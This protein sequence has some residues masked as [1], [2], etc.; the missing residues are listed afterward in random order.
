[1]DFPLSH[2]IRDM[3]C[4]DTN[5][6]QCGLYRLYHHL[7]QDFVYPDTSMLFRFI[8][9][10]DVD[11]FF[12]AEPHDI[13]SLKQAVAIIATI[14]GIPQLY[15]G[16]EVLLYGDRSK[17]DGFIRRDFP[18]GWTG[19]PRNCFKREGRTELQNEAF[20]FCK[21][22]FT[23]RKHSKAL[24]HGSMKMFRPQHGV[25]QRPL[26]GPAFAIAHTAK[27]SVQ[28]LHTHALSY[29]CVRR[30]RALPSPRHYARA[31]RLTL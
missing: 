16:T 7:S 3:V 22:I 21:T 12:T 14:P 17:C 4:V 1:M 26:Q 10:H 6:S 11:R 31:L 25:E 23:F 2:A 19:D 28:Y 27:I 30:T 24:A 9:N 8:D 29:A 5:D 13:R 15:Y 20:D 18:G